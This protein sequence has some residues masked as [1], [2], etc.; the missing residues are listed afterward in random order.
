MVKVKQG[1]DGEF[2]WDPKDKKRL[3]SWVAQYIVARHYGNLRLAREL[4]KRLYKQFMELDIPEEN[5]QE[6]MFFFG[7]PNNL[8][9]RDETFQEAHNFMSWHPNQAWSW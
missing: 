3:M 5:Q 1:Q 9:N 4:K 2:V 6:I 7:D 8:S